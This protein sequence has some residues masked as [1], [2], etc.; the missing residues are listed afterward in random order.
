MYPSDYGYATEGGSITNSST[1]LSTGMY[2]WDY[3]S[4]CH[5]NDYL[6]KSD[7]Y[8]WT[9]MP[10]LN[11]IDAAFVVVG[12][13]GFLTCIADFESLATRPALYLKSNIQ[14]KSGDGT[15]EIPYQ[16]NL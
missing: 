4:D 11:K 1:C 5:G 6:Y 16:L 13:G 12:G 10:N 8:Q 15:S 2:G 14:T 3:Y 7:Y 9:L